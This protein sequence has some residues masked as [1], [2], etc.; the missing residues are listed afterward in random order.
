MGKAGAKYVQLAANPAAGNHCAERLEGLAM[1]FARAGACVIRS[2]CGPH[3]E[4]EIDGRADHVCVVGGDGTFRH[5][6]I[7]AARSG[8]RVPL[9]LYPA[10]TV[11][12][13]HREVPCELDP[14]LYASRVVRGKWPR[15]HYAADLGESLFLACA[16]VG[17]DSAAVAAVSPGLKRRIGR[18]AYVIAF[19][20][21]LIAWPRPRIRLQC[22]SHR[23]ECEAFYVAK[24]RFFA[25]PWSFAPEARL[26]HP[27]LHVVALERATRFSYARFVWALWRGRTDGKLRGTQT[28]ICTELEAEA[29]LPVP[30]QADGD[31]AGLLP[32]KIRLRPEPIIFH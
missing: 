24:G 13:I 9:S 8:S 29:D 14:D 12:L 19:L 21:V 7:A 5:V 4:F 11:N 15:S 32:A 6:A 26:D 23:I 2:E 22:G 1:A 27:S 28:F 25:G 3:R 20:R 10:G 30:I 17:P 18:L 16:S 31:F